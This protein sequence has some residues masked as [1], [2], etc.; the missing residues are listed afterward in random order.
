MKWFCSK[1]LIENVVEHFDSVF[2]GIITTKIKTNMS[3]VTSLLMHCSHALSHRFMV[4]CDIIS[5][6]VTIPCLH[7]IIIIPT[8]YFTITFH[9]FTN[10]QNIPQVASG[11]WHH[12]VT[13]MLA[14]NHYQPSSNPIN[15]SSIKTLTVLYFKAATSAN[16]SCV[17]FVIGARFHKPTCLSLSVMHRDILTEKSAVWN[18]L[19]G[20]KMQ[21]IS[22]CY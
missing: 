18:D 7:L 4:T 5:T 22:L 3:M 15:F 13:S 6:P 12:V 17:R 14:N 21:Y 1:Q 10:T 16:Y 19:H 11:Y 9:V 2:S 8:L 20:E